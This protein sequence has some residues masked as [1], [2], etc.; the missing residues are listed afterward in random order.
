M[1]P[2]MMKNGTKRLSINTPR[3]ESR[4][5]RTRRGEGQYPS[6]TQNLARHNSSTTRL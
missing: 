6:A 2:D 4:A 1:I 3:D 5:S